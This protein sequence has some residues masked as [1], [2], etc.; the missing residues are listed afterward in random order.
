ML[1]P[2][3]PGLGDMDGDFLTC[4]QQLREEQLPCGEPSLSLLL[5]GAQCRAA[6]TGPRL[7]EPRAEGRLPPALTVHGCPAQGR[8]SDWP[9][10]GRLV[11]PNKPFL[12]NPV[13]TIN[14]VDTPLLRAASP[15]HRRREWGEAPVRWRSLVPSCSPS[16]ISF[17]MSVFYF[18]RQ[19]SLIS[20]ELFMTLMF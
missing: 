16:T 13:E 18:V 17:R 6:C 12:I 20:H 10:V 19:Q 8:L 3:L 9:L 7:W 14:K 5:G 2:C 11:D 15:A 1:S 4:Q